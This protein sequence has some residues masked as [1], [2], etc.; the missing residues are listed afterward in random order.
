MDS[1]IHKVTFV[2]K[3]YRHSLIDSIKQFCTNCCTIGNDLIHSEKIPSSQ[4]LSSTVRSF[5]HLRY[6]QN[7]STVSINKNWLTL[8]NSDGLKVP[9]EYLQNIDNR[10]EMYVICN[11]C[12]RTKSTSI[13]SQSENGKSQ[14]YA[15]TFTIDSPLCTTHS[16]EQ[17]ENV[18]KHKSGSKLEISGS[19]NQYRPRSRLSKLFGI[20]RRFTNTFGSLNSIAH[21][22][23]YRS[24]SPAN[25]CRVASC[26]RLHIHDITPK[27]EETY[28]PSSTCSSCQHCDETHIGPNH[29]QVLIMEQL[30]R[31]LNHNLS[32][33]RKSTEPHLSKSL[34]ESDLIEEKK[35]S[36]SNELLNHTRSNVITQSALIKARLAHSK[37]IYRPQHSPTH[38]YRNVNVTLRAC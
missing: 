1:P 9:L 22:Q 34:I 7:D 33:Y 25:Y 19:M 11:E 12:K 18:H 29:D 26:Q 32:S 14:S 5:Y 16:M 23:F 20:K 37:P 6:D 38:L 3:T 27:C 35:I 13:G 10:I 8:Y 36:P 24:P 21:T 17:L 15:L 30:V 2:P 31:D 28:A 4:S